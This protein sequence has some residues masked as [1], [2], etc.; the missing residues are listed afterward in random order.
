MD[1]FDLEQQILECWKIT[2]DIAMMESQGANTADMTSLACVYEYKFKRLWE[3]FEGMVNQ[4]QFKSSEEFFES[5][6]ELARRLDKK[7]KKHNST[8]S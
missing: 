3:I 1:R 7:S 5:G 8:K 6:R 2:D 4:R